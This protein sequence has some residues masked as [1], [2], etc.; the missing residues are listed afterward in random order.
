VRVLHVSA[1]YAP[2]FVYGG[3]PRSIHGLCRA[4]THN[5]VDVE[6][7]TTNANGAGVLP[8]EITSQPAYDGVTVRYFSRAWP[9]TPIG[10]SALVAAIRERLPRTD[11]V[12]VHGLWNRVVWGV[13]SECLRSSVPYVLSP[14]GMLQGPAVAHHRWRKQMAFALFERRTIAHAAL[15]H[16]T[17]EAE[18]AAI[19]A[20]RDDAPVV[21]IPNGIAI[22]EPPVPTRD[23]LALPEDRV[24]VLFVGRLHA[25]K[26]VDLLL[27]AFARLRGAH[28]EAHLVIAG[29]DEQ[30]LRAGLGLRHPEL[31]G[32]VS[33]LGPVDAAERHALL[34]RARALVLC[35]DSEGFGMVVLEALAA[36]RPAVVT[37]TCGWSLLATAGA[38][39]VVPQS[40][41]AIADALGQLVADRAKA[42]AMGGRGRRL[43]ESTFTWDAVARAF[44]REYE[45]TARV[46]GR[47]VAC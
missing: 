6:V 11:L 7:L 40:A 45:A 13:V 33:W 37:D 30:N 16:A 42:D 24:V 25:M 22:D 47:E 28:P 18:R 44:R 38:G 10:S 3:P 23:P 8:A 2:A 32:A 35:S 34:A 20:W 27:D 19:Q 41:A 1:Y 5:G 36:S 26:R 12:H 15:I 31:A 4:L 17:S 46:R 39:L 14:R 43:V 21:V 29:P 9:A